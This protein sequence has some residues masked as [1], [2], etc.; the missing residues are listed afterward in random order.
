MLMHVVLL[1]HFSLDGG[2]W[3]RTHSFLILEIA[4]LVLLP[5]LVD[6][7]RCTSFTKFT[8]K[9]IGDLIFKILTSF[10]QVGNI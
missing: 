6:L 4:H 10:E 7:L 5:T 2:P 9:A 8:K 3:N 1:F